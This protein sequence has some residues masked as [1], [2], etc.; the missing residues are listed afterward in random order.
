MFTRLG[1]FAVR[2]RGVALTL[3]TIV[4]VIAAMLGPGVIDRL[5]GSGFDDPDADSVAARAELDRIFDTGFPDLVFL[6]E[7]NVGT[8]N[9]GVVDRAVMRD[10]GLAFTEEIAAID[11]TDDVVSYWSTGDPAL[12]SIDERSA[13]LLLRL[14]GDENDPA[15]EELS[16][17]LVED[18]ARV[19]R[20]PLAIRIAGRDAVFEHIGSIAESDLTRAELIA[21]PLTL[22]LLMVVFRTVVAALVP[23]L[24]GIATL[25]GALLVLYLITAFTDVSIFA[26]NLV[27]T[28]GL[29]LAID[30]SLL[31]VSRFR[32]ERAAGYTVD[33]AVRRTVRTAGRTVAFSGLTVAVSLSA[34]LIFP[35][36]F[37]RSFAY[38]GIGVV[39]FALLM[40][41]IAVPAALSLLGDRIES[42]TVRRRPRKRHVI[43]IWR[44]RADLVVDH[45]WRYLL[46][47]TAILVALAAPFA[48]VEWGEADH[49]TLPAD[50][51]IR[52]TTEQILNQFDSSEAN[53][54]PM[55][56]LGNVDNAAVTAHALAV[57]QLPG[58]TRVDS[59]TGSFTAGA[60]VVPA[61]DG[62][63]DRFLR[64]SEDATWFNIVPSVDPI[65]AAGERL[66]TDLRTLDTPFAETL[67]GGGAASFVDTKAAILDN[68]PLA[69]ALLFGST[70]VLLFLTFG[71]LL[72]PLKAIVLNILSLG[73]TFGMLV[74]VFQEGV[75]AGFLGVTA[76][77][78]T[79]L[80]TVVLIFGIAFGL[81]MDYEVFL[82][83]RIKEEYDASGHPQ[84]SVVEGIDRTGP[85][86]SAAALLLTVTFLATATSSLA[87]VKMFGLGL[88]VAVVTDAFLVRITVVPALM[89]LAGKW[90]WWAPGPLRRLHDRWGIPDSDTGVVIDLRDDEAMIDLTRPS[91]S[92]V[93]LDLRETEPETEPLFAAFPR[94]DD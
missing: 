86:I 9:S 70:Y 74:V 40:S 32:E 72:V 24:V 75:G 4:L 45:P 81:S 25:L 54:I 58:V 39:A 21:I 18:Y 53:A 76:A 23:A 77:G 31:V 85:I 35:I 50:D 41:L 16:I 83:S 93:D 63:R 65:S 37:L 19:Q 55:L 71:S 73:A 2:R 27:T 84:D 94:D 60:A 48:L 1:N 46:G 29:G 17:R 62:A 92:R 38:A 20:G 59:A 87:F 36:Y 44:E 7:T 91:P 69:A 42:L 10:A 68:L 66:V 13:L 34:L 88:A 64:E 51:A 56:A 12:R 61:D 78:T 14:P 79:D 15:R 22:L 67:V 47:G 5:A 43:S 28:L 57:S 90:N 33:T 11:G 82:L 49:R 80:S 30:Y 6:M 26:I 3:T 52:R 89:T 8:P